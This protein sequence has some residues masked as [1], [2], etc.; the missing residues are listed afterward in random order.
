MTYVSVN[1]LCKSFDGSC[2]LDSV[3]LDLAARELVVLMGP[4]GS[5]KTT[6]LRCMS[7]LETLDR[8]EILIDGIDVS[9]VPTRLRGIGMVFQRPSLFPNL[10]VRKNLLL[11]LR[12]NGAARVEAEDR[13]RDLLDLMQLAQ[14][15][16]RYPHELSGGQEQRVALARALAPAPPVL[17]LDEPFSAVD[18]VVRVALREAVRDIQR[19]L[20]TTMV[21]V[22]HDQSEALAIGERVAI[23]SEGKIHGFGTP[24]ELYDAPSDQM[25]ASFL[26]PRNIVRLR[27]TET[28]RRWREALGV[29]DTGSKNEYRTWGSFLPESVRLIPDANSLHGVIERIVFTGPTTRVQL[30]VLNQTISA[31]VRSDSTADLVEGMTVGIEVDTRR[32]RCFE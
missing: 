14:L 20:G 30:R 7:G 5:G 12:A 6:L 10:T 8:G 22:T 9:R 31:D 13:V 27:D 3:S 25:T 1:G 15:H 4:S 16:D 17:L 26:G 2:V 24:R 28:S 29:D 19:E 11:P 23:L 18:A 21:Y 32:V